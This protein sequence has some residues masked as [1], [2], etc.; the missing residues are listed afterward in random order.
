MNGPFYIR[1]PWVYSVAAAAV[2]G[3]DVVSDAVQVMS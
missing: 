2:D 3:N 1:L